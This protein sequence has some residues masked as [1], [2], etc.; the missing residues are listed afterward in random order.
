V[1]FQT[2]ADTVLGNILNHSFEQIW[3]THPLLWKLRT[4]EDLEDYTVD[5][6]KVGCGGCPD[7]YICGGCRA[8][9]YSYF[10]GNVKGP[11]VGCVHNKLLWEKIRAQEQGI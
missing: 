11:D 5:G 10:R 2:G 9:A 3:D 8:R 6:K 4:R 7:K 1:F